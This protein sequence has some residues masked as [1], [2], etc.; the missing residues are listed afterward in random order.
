M[1]GGSM[2]DI[3]GML[4]S[5][6]TK[7]DVYLLPWLEVRLREARNVKG[8]YAIPLDGEIIYIGKSHDIARRLYYQNHP[9]HEYRHSKFLILPIADPAVRGYCEHTVIRIAQPRLNRHNGQ[10]IASRLPEEVVDA[11]YEMLFGSK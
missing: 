1:F 7:D 11:G 4:L 2:E 8:V 10:L 9:A 5:L 3:T 6:Q